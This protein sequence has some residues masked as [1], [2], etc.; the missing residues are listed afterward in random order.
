MGLAAYNSG[1]PRRPGR[2]SL[3][4]DEA[5]RVKDAL[6]RLRDESYGGNATKLGEALGMSQSGVSQ[7]I[8]GKNT[9]S[10][11][12]AKE[13]AKA[14]GVDVWALLGRE[15]EIIV[16]DKDI[17]PNRARAIAAAKLLHMSENSIARVR[18]RPG[19]KSDEDRPARSWFRLIQAEHEMAEEAPRA[20]GTALN[21][22]VADLPPAPPRGRK[23][24]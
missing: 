9:P 6:K 16:L 18:D 21:P 15:E 17:Y 2:P 8:N 5:A 23:S 22:S 13:L 14:I 19:A 24:R 7:I 20:I 3:P 11:E 12:T 10:F 4:A 1:V